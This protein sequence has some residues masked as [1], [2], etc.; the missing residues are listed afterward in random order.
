L[1]MVKLAKFK[2]MNVEELRKQV[3]EL[4][5][6]LFRERSAKASTGR[7]SNPGKLRT[8]RRTVAVIKTLLKQR[9]LKI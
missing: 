2:E 4:E 8:I 7:P 9:G 1:E 5:A 3:R 6:E